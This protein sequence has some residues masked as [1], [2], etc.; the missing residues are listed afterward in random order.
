VSLGNPVYDSNQGRFISIAEV[1]HGAREASAS[2]QSGRTLLCRIASFMAP[3]TLA[4]KLPSALDSA[5]L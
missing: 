2:R 4:M 5:V 1:L 3:M